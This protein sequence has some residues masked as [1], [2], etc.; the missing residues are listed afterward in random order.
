MARD[1]FPK[2]V[3]EKLRARVAHRCSNPSCRVPTSGPSSD[4]KVN[5][6]FI[7]TPTLKSDS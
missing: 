1:N 5:N 3:I 4:N 2:K 6:D 7:E